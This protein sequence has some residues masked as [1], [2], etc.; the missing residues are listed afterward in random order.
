[1][2]RFLLSSSK[3]MAT[4]MRAESVPPRMLFPVMLTLPMLPPICS[5]WGVLVLKVKVLL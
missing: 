5:D 1:M 4:E 3:E 2:R